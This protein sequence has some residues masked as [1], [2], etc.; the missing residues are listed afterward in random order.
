MMLAAAV[1]GIACAVV[2]GDETAAARTRVDKDAAK[3]DGHVLLY[4]TAA[5]TLA[6]GYDGVSWY[7]SDPAFLAKHADGVRFSKGNGGP[8]AAT[9]AV[10]AIE[11]TKPQPG[12]WHARIRAKPGRVYLAGGW[13][14]FGNAKLLMWFGGNSAATGKA[15]ESRLYYMSGFNPQLRPYFSEELLKRLG[16]DPEKWR[17]VYRLVEFPEKLREDVVHVEY[18]LYLAAGDV[19]FSEPFFVDVTDAPRTLDIDIAGA[20]PIRSLSVAGTE[21]RDIRWSKTFEKPVTDFRC[22]LPP[23][24]DAFLGQDQNRPRGHTLTVQYADGTVETVGA[25]LDNVFKVRK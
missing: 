5:R 9:N 17:C 25:P 6:N 20:R 21:L 23:E 16:G 19:K 13:F 15:V 3:H 22:T 10:Y 4:P 18:G 24:I 7:T 8:F 12:Y 11:S 14:R 1:I 2:G